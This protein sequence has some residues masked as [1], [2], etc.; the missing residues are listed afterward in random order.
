MNC[1]KC[2]STEE[3]SIKCRLRNGTPKYI[4][5]T[6]RRADYH[7]NKGKHNILRNDPEEMRRIRWIIDWSMLAEEINSRVM[8]K[9]TKVSL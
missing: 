1:I 3:L 2:D 9:Y 5:R 6:C 4:C 7:Q 8:N